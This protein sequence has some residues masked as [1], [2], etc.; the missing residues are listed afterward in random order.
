MLTGIQTL[1]KVALPPKA[2]EIAG[3]PQFLDNSK[4]LQ[5]RTSQTAVLPLYAESELI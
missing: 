3:T 5:T 2:L 4:L 1:P